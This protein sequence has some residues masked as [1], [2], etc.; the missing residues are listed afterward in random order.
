MKPNACGLL[1]LFALSC[2]S[3]L[4]TVAAEK[5]DPPANDNY[6]AGPDSQRQPGVPV[7]KIFNFVFTESKVFPGTQRNISVYVPAQYRAEK[8]ACVYVGL[9]GLG[10]SAPIVF[11]N[12]IH[13]GEIPLLIA[14]GVTPGQVSSHQSPANPRFNRS[15]EFD[16]LNDQ[17]A[18]LIVDEILPAVERQ[19]TPNGLPI[20]LSRDPNDRCTGGGSTGGIGAFT[21]AWERP[22]AF[23]R[24]FSAIGTFVGMRGGDRYPVLVRKTEPKPIRIFLQDGAADQWMGGP[25]VGDWWMS[26]QTMQRALE[27]AGYDQRF[28]WGTGPHSG[29]HATALFPDAMRWLWRDWPNPI[30]PGVSQ[31]TF[32]KA[33]LAENETWQAVPGAQPG[34]A[35]PTTD[36][37]GNCYFVDRNRMVQ[38]LGADGKI[39]PVGAQADALAASA[40]GGLYLADRATGTITLRG[41]DGSQKVLAEK[42]AARGLFATAAGLLYAVDDDSLWLVQPGGQKKI[43]SGLDHPTGVVAS[44][45]GLWLAVAESRSHWGYSYRLAAD[46]AVELKQKYYWF[47]VPDWADDSGVAGWCADRDGRLYAATRMGIEVFDRNGRVRCILPTPGGAALAVGFAG[48]QFDTLLVVTPAGLLRRKVQTRGLPSAAPAVKLPAWGAG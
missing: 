26:N 28:E 1:V 40:N 31:N 2:A 7:G 25:E 24:V 32:L 4:P 38:R 46:G 23:R 45:D 18:R 10:F 17:L 19:K 33:I 5:K 20:K 8:P 13:K 22:D 12:L 34:P 27:F 41:A 48:P 29:R 6:P 36:A 16:G 3:L 35:M 30:V 43:D 11:D 37:Q 39:S 47:H 15:F 44:P 9:D 42:L 21:L 14:V